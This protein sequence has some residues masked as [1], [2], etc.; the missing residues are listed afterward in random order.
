[1]GKAGEDICSRFGSI[2]ESAVA[3]LDTSVTAGEVLSSGSK[4][5]F[6]LV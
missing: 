2:L 4:G 6:V 1:M 3:L 5:G